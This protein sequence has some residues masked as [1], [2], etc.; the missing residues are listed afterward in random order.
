[1]DDPDAIDVA[2]VGARV[3]G[4]VLGTLLGEAGFRVLIVDSTTFPSDTISTH[5]FRGAGLGSVLVRLGILEQVLALGAPPLT[6]QLD[7]GG[8]DVEPSVSGP[9]DPGELGYGLS[10]RRVVLDQLLVDR[11]RAVPGVEIL[12]G[13]H[14]RALVWDG[15]RVAGLVAEHAGTTREIRARLVVG[16]DGR[17]SAVAR[18]VD[19]AVERRETA[20]RALYYRYVRGF[21][22][23]R[24]PIDAVEFSLAGDELAYIFPSDSA[25]AC[26]AVSINLSTFAGFRG[27]ADEH[28]DRR[29]A[30]HL[31]IAGRYAASMKEGRLLGSGPVDAL[32]RTPFG[33]GWALVG[34]AAMNQDPWSGLG[35]DNASIHATF[36]AEAINEWLSGRSDE[37]TAFAAYRERRDGHALGGFDFTANFGRDL[38]ALVGD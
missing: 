12:E 7:F 8:E 29:I 27:A 36:L 30:S 11:A 37:A 31:G 9:Q 24:P 21:D 15:D 19:A 25:L 17:R 6:H 10:V 14:A 2:I 4:T 32:I 3:A 1:L 22:R 33:H 38:R 28:F 23:L 13:T 5:F 16:A 18:W 35:M 26:V 34:D 20:T